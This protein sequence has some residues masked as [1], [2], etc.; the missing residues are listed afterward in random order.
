MVLY[1][2]PS[3]AQNPSLIVASGLVLSTIPKAVVGA[4]FTLNH[5]RNDSVDHPLTLGES[6]THVVLLHRLQKLFHN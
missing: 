6:L 2:L 5:R 3:I 4:I 1:F